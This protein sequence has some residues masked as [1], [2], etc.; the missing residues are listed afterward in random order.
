MM[1][2]IIIII[3]I[4]IIKLFVVRATSVKFGLCARDMKFI[5]H[6]RT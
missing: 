2:I 6:V 4:V 3:I 5:R 1:M